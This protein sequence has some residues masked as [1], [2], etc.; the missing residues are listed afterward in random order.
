MSTFCTDLHP[1]LS[2]NVEGTGR[3]LRMSRKWG[4]ASLDLFQRDY[5]LLEKENSFKNFSYKKN[6]IKIWQRFS[7]W[8]Q[9]QNGRTDGR[10]RQ[11]KPP[12]S[13]N[14]A[15]ILSKVTQNA[16]TLTRLAVSILTIPRYTQNNED[17]GGVLQSLLV[18]KSVQGSF[19]SH[20]YQFIVP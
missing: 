3:N 17:F 10:V 20:T 9:V 14:N 8:H 16:T 12:F 11:I 13:V 15:W 5:S 2:R 1:N 4:T 19:L 6:F 18:L 7:L